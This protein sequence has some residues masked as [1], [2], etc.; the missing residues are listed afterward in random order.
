MSF[1]ACYTAQGAALVDETATSDRR[2]TYV[3]LICP[4]AETKIYRNY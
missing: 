3:A 1:Y 4:Y 2:A